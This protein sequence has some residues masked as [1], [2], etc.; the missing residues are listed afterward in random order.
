MKTI[1][2]RKINFK[3][4]SGE[5]IG[6]TLLIPFVL[7]LIVAIL[8]ATQISSINQKL[9]YSTYVTA[10]TA[11]VSS[12]DDQVKIRVEA[13]LK[14]M[15]GENYDTVQVCKQGETPTK[16]EPAPNHLYATIEILGPEWERGT[17]IRCTCV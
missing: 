2:F 11:S 6:F 9:T 12:K 4:G 1:N 8:S 13:V 14:D 5:I 16:L 10:R 3:K 7:L 17:M 15:Y